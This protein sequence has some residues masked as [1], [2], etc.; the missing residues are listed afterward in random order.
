[1]WRAIVL[2]LLKS[3]WAGLFTGLAEPLDLDRLDFV[4]RASELDRPILLLHSDDDGFVPDTASRA[5][6][7]ARPDIV[8]YV[9]FDEARH[10]KLWNYDRTRWEDA[11]RD[12][13]S[14]LPEGTRSAVTQRR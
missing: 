5:L 2:T 8:T 14:M 4:R 7:A 3:R 1:M 6:A 11:I 13:L 10:T 12:W 9:P